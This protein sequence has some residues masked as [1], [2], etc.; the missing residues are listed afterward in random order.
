MQNAS[1]DKAQAGI[2][3]ARRN[4]NNLR[5]TDD[6]TLMGESEE[7]LKSLLMKGKEESEKTGLKLNI[8][9]TKTMA[10]D[11]TTWWQID[12]ENVE[13]ESDFIFL[14]YIITTDIWR[15][16]QNKK[17][18]A[19][20]KKTYDKPRQCVTKQRL[21]LPTKVPVAKAVLF[22]VVIYGCE[23]CTIK[24][25]EKQRIVLLNCDAGKD[26]RESPGQ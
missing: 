14:D 25:A 23:S 7:E 22:P 1:L 17:T 16:P 8:Q 13:T 12:G 10:S 21:T 15:Q 3:I 6:T 9:K 20:W 18:L 5:Y 4:V 26:C 11:P 19:P 24:K 2:N